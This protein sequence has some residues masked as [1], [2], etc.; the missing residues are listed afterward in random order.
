[1]TLY[2]EIKDGD[3]VK[4]IRRNYKWQCCDCGLV[5]RVDF[6]TSPRGTL[7]FRVRRDNRATAAVRRRRRRPPAKP[8]KSFTAIAK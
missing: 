8:H 4:P 1:M 3:W 5:H 6:H 2:L 7:F